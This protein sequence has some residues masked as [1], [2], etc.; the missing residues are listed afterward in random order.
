M[1]SRKPPSLRGAHPT[2]PVC[3]PP[4]SPVVVQA[5]AGPPTPKESKREVEPRT[6][7]GVL[8]SRSGVDGEGLGDRLGEGLGEGVR[9]AGEGEGRLHGAR[10]FGMA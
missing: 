7:P 3:T 6:G 5:Q 2:A 1:G 8:G 4:D 9:G 10:G